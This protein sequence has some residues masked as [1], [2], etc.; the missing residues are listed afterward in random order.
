MWENHF[1][2]IALLK[3]VQN[4]NCSCFPQNFKEVLR[5]S[6]FSATSGF[7]FDNGFIS[8]AKGED[9]RIKSSSPFSSSSW[10]AITKSIAIFL[11]KQC[12][13]I[14]IIIDGIFVILNKSIPW[15][16]MS[17]GFLSSDFLFLWRVPLNIG[18][19]KSV[20][21]RAR[22]TKIP[23]YERTV[24]IKC[25]LLCKT[26]SLKWINNVHSR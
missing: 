11:S 14:P 12:Y 19:W 4:R 15:A 21:Y 13:Y 16:A 25:S 2:K 7:H 5:I 3:V 24:P 22:L 17:S 10:R 20:V 8:G 6:I 1:F 18:C 23:D 9:H 26:T